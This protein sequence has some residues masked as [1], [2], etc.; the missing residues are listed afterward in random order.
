M[1][2]RSELKN[3]RARQRQGPRTAATERGVRETTTTATEGGDGDGDGVRE[4]SE[5]KNRDGEI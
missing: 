5:M 1:K 2:E 3:E 4:R